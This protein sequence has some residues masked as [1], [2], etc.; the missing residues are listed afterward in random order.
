MK[1][2]KGEGRVG[3]YHKT[4]KS[5]RKF[6]TICGGHLFTDHPVWGVI[7]VYAATIPA[8]RHEPKLGTSAPTT[9]FT[10]WLAYYNIL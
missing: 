10:N 1:V 2:T 3:V 7:D 8:Y 6:C 4:E 5:Y 9:L